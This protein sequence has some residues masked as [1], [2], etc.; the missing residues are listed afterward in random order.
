ML[1]L[2][3]AGDPHGEVASAYLAEEL[4]REVYATVDGAEARRRSGAV[5]TTTAAEP[6]GRPHPA[7]SHP[8]SLA[9]QVLAWPAAGSPNG[10]TEA[11]NLLVKKIERFGHCFA[12]SRTTGCACCS[13]AASDGRLALLHQCE[14]VTPR[15]VA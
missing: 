14:A 9:P 5:S 3:E 11:V 8:A 4:L 13:T 2:L 15:L 1:V 12:T 6:D 7:G 10:P